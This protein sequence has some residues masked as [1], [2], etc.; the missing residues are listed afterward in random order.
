MLKLLFEFLGTLFLTLAFNNTQGLPFSQNQTSVLLTLWVLTIFGMKISGAHYN[1][2]ISIAFML[3]KDIGNFPRIL[4][5]AYVV[6][7]CLG[8]FCGALISW[9]L[10]NNI[11]KL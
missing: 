3:R 4:G 7:Q 9:F 2:A 1:P 10:L 8:A 6:A 5:V 11:Q